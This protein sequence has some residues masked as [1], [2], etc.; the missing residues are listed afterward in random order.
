M[1]TG[2]TETVWSLK[3]LLATG[4]YLRITCFARTP[5]ILRPDIENTVNFFDR[6]SKN[7]KMNGG[8][9]KWLNSW[10]LQAL[11]TPKGFTKAW[12]V[13]GPFRTNASSWQQNNDHR[14]AQVSCQVEGPLYN[15]A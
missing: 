14:K 12:A 6:N 1:K 9:Q 5:N 8:W 10:H 7:A 13:C 15:T 3:S 2:L 11:M 4:T